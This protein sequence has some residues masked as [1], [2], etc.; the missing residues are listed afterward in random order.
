MLYFYK[1]NYAVKNSFDL[2]PI[3]LFVYNRPWH[4]QQT[5]EALFLN[6]LADESQLII[7]ADGAKGNASDE[8]IEKINEVRSIIRMKSW[9][10]SV[11]IIESPINKG[12]ANS[13]IEGVTK[14]VNHYGKIIVLEDDIVTSESFLIYMNNCL[15]MYLTDDAVMHVSGYMYP[16]RY[17]KRLPNTFFLRSISCWGWGT[18]SRAWEKFEKN[19]KQQIELLNKR[20][21]WHA[22][23][24]AGSNDSFQKQLEQNETHEINTWAIFWYTT[25]FLN[26]GLALFPKTSFVQNIGHDGSGIH[27]FAFGSKRN[28]YYWDSLSKNVTLNKRKLT[29]NKRHTNYLKKYFLQISKVDVKTTLR[30]KFYLFRKKFTHKKSSIT[31]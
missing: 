5:L 23:N 10:K 24:V 12:L 3:V 18:W 30:D 25:V 27:C 19:P 26:K 11:E 22:F 9:C 29:I 14:I 4:T 1:K 8:E 2:A 15:N 6:D 17:N 16:T 13:I 20:N 7:Y 21:L 28:P 31:E